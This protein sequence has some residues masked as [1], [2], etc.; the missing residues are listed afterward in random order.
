M[1]N[2]KVNTAQIN[3]MFEQLSQLSATTH[4]K[5]VKSEVGSILE[6]TIQNTRAAS[7]TKIRKQYERFVPLG[8]DAY[9]PKQMRKFGRLIGG[10]N[11]L[12]Y[13]ENRYPNALWSRLKDRR[14][15]LIR[16]KLAARGLSKQSWLQ[17]GDALGIKVDAPEY[18]RNARATTGQIYENV[19][20]SSKVSSGKIE[21]TFS[22]GQPTV[23]AI[24]GGQALKRAIQG[25]IKYFEN[26]AEHSV[27]A[28]VKQIARAYPG[29]KIKL[30]A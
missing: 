14:A 24:G 7:A 10:R 13:M 2:E 23:N 12:Y 9:S 5:V 8:I 22:N 1:A 27:F 28:D 21:I 20:A 4:E 6:K 17:V 16:T 18:V 29:L 19:K 3:A 11:L 25:R 15:A 26:N 30:A